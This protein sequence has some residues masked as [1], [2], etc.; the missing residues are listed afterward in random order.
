MGTGTRLRKP[1]WLKAPLG[2]G[3]SLPK[4]FGLLDDLNLH[5][6]CQEAR[7]P[8]LGECFSHGTATFMI[9]GDRCTRRCH[10]CAVDTAR[11]LELDPFEPVR[12]AEAAARLGLRHV[13][14]TAVARDDLEDGGA[15][16]FA[17]TVHALRVRL[18]EATVEVLIPDFKGDDRALGTVLE[19]G[20]DVLN[21]NI[22]AVR[23]IFPEVRPQ[24][25][26][27]RSLR[28]LRRAKEMRPGCTT[29][30]GLIV[31]FGESEDEVLETLRDLRAAGCEVVTIGQY[32]QPTPQHRPVSE[33]VHPDRF[34]SYR[35]AGEA[36]G[37]AAVFSGPLVRSSYHAG[38]V[39]ERV[40]SF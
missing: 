27:D 14:V 11:P 34:R 17:A 23:R 25:S 12:V 16:H 3:G 20:P 38:E 2:G 32:L 7:C 19:A 6:V 22:E 39:F 37:F 30:S 24:G 26:Y 13:V 4:V 8:N 15:G 28:L 33:Y 10:Y 40:R 5:T 29:K 35:E 21:H 31:G 9:C 36:M 18:P 1:E